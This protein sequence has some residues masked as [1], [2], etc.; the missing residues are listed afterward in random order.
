MMKCSRELKESCSDVVGF[1]GC[2]LYQ[3]INHMPFLWGDCSSLI[4]RDLRHVLLLHFRYVRK[5]QV[6]KKCE[7]CYL[8]NKKYTLFPNLSFPNISEMKQKDVPLVK[9]VHL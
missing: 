5:T 1:G 2:D 4:L 6:G 7:C 3:S 8:T 9:I